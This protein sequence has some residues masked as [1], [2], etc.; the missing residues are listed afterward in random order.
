MFSVFVSNCKVELF[1]EGETKSELNLL[2]GKICSKLGEKK[3]KSTVIE[4][5]EKAL[6]LFFPTVSQ[7]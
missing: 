6:Q 2:E 4:L 1:G 3:I 5:N 7:C